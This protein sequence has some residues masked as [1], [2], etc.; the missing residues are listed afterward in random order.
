MTK[1]VGGTGLSH[2]CPKQHTVMVHLCS[3]SL[4]WS[5]RGIYQVCIVLW[6]LSH[7]I[8]PPFF[9][10][11]FHLPINLF[12]LL[13]PSQCLLSREPKSEEGQW[14]FFCFLPPC[15]NTPVDVWLKANHTLWHSPF[16][17]WLALSVRLIIFLGKQTQSPLWISSSWQDKSQCLN[18]GS[19][20]KLLSPAVPPL[21]SKLE[22]L[23]NPILWE[24]LGTNYHF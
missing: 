13:A 14:A 3:K 23:G 6:W 8:L 17:S 10:S 4:F 16:S 12:L 1:Q 5:S 19:N 24:L 7:P 2:F 21:F 11:K 22:L 9:F 18:W 15:L 20:R